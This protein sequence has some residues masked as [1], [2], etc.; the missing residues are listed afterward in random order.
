MGA[1]QAARQMGQNLFVPPQVLLDH[2]HVEEG[3]GFLRVV[4]Q[5]ERQQAEVAL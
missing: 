1:L 5:R 2:A 3:E 4:A